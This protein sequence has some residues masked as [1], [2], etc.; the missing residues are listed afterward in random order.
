MPAKD[1]KSLIEERRQPVTA[2]HS[3]WLGIDPHELSQDV[4]A[5]TKR[6]AYDRLPEG[7]SSTI[8]SS[9]YY[10]GEVMDAYLHEYQIPRTL[11]EPKKRLDPHSPYLLRHSNVSRTRLQKTPIYGI[12]RDDKKVL[13]YVNDFEDPGSTSYLIPSGL[14]ENKRIGHLGPQFITSYTLGEDLDTDAFVPPK[15]G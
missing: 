5:G 11:I 6:S 12:E 9:D 8:R 4:H 13:Q 10:E 1:L 7:L 3:N 15:M 14:V 2:Y